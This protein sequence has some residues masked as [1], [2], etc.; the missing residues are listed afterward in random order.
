MAVLAVIAEIAT[1]RVLFAVATAATGRSFGVFLARLVTC[2]AG[3]RSMR[4]FKGEVGFS[5]L[6]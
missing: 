2:A 3:R 6:E 4:T 5:V 1:V